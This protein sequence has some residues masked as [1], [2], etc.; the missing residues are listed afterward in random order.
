MYQPMGVIILLFETTGG[1]Y[2][3]GYSNITSLRCSVLVE[4]IL[5]NIILVCTPYNVMKSLRED[6]TLS[7][8]SIFSHDVE[9][10]ICSATAI[11]A[12]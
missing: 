10:F 3:A 4:P 5:R 9:T 6:T 2:I 8:E 1:G 7:R 12:V 11:K